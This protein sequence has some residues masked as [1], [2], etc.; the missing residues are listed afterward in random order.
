M[1]APQIQSAER[2]STLIFADR[3]SG[4]ERGLAFPTSVAGGETI[5]FVVG[6][7]TDGNHWGDSTAAD[8]TIRPALAADLNQDGCIDRADLALLLQQIRSGSTDPVYDLN[9]DG[10]VDMADATS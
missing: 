7:G 3:I 6:Y 9:S 4:N 2:S 5:D 8:I 1:R 10:R